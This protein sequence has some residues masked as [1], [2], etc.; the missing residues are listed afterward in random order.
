MCYWLVITLN[1]TVGIEALLFGKPVITLADACY[2]V[3]AL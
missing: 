3:M 1:S 2:N